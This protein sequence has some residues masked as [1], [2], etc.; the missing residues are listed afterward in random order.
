M[1]KTN[2]YQTPI[3]E[4][5]LESL[6]PEVKDQFLDSINNIPFIQ[7]LISP[8]R[9]RACDLDRDDKGR[10]IIDLAN[11][12]IVE[13]TDYFRPAAIHYQKH[14][15]Y[16]LL[17]P[18]SN[19]NSEYYKWVKEETRRCWEGYIRESD[20]EWVTGYLYF[21][22]NYSPIMLSAITKGT[23]QANR[24]YDFPE[25]WEGVYWR[26]HYM[27]QG[28]YG[29]KYNDFIGGNHGA[30][31]SSRGKA[32]PVT[33]KVPTPE[34]FKLWGDI[35]VGDLLFGTD[36]TTTKVTN[37]PYEGIEDIYN[38]YLKD[39]RMVQASGNHLFTLYKR[40]GARNSHRV[41]SVN[42]I[43]D[44]L[45]YSRKVTTRNPND[46][47]YKYALYNHS[48]VE[49]TYKNTL[50]D[51]YTFGLLLGDGCFRHKSCYYTCEDSDFLTIKKYLPYSHTKWKGKFGYNINIPKWNSILDFYNL[52]NLESED[53]FIPEEYIINSR[54]V[55]LEVLKGLMDSDGFVD[56]N[57]IPIIGLSSE[58]MIDNV[59]SIC[60]SLGYNC[61]KSVKPGGYK[62]DGV[63]KECKNSY[64]LRIYTTDI[65][66]KLPRKFKLQS[67]FISRYS[68]SN[69]KYSTIIDIQFSHKE[70]AKCVTVDSKDSNYLVGEYVP[71]HNSKS[72]SLSS[73][74][75][76]NFTLGINSTAHHKT[77][78]IVTAY[79]KEYLTKD[80]VLNKFVTNIDFLADNTQFPRKRLQSSF[81]QMA[82]KMGY[83]DAELDI[84]KGTLNTVLGVSS[85]DDESK[86]RGKRA[87]FIAI[88]EF[89]SFRK[90]KETYNVLIPSVQEG[91]IV[92]GQLFLTGTSGD[93]ESD[94]AGAQEIVYNPRG[95]N[96]YA[97][98]NNFDKVN[99]GKKEFV[100]FFGGYV[101]RKGCYN[102]DGVSDVVAAL[103][104]ILN[105][106][107][108]VK[109]NSSDPNTILKTIAEI[110]I[111][112]SEAIIKAGVNMFPVTDLT[113]RL[114]QLEANPNIINEIYT[115]ELVL[116]KG[117][118][119]YV[120]SQKEPIRD[121]PFKGSDLTGCLEIVQMPEKNREGSVFPDRYI[122]GLDPIDD[123]N[124]NNNNSLAAFYILDLWTDRLVAHYIGRPLYAEDLYELVRKALI[125]YNAR[126]NYE[127]NLKGIFS[128]FSQ[129]NCT[130]LLTDTLEF[131]KDKQ[132]IKSIG[133][134]NLSKGTRATAAINNYARNLLRSWL[135]KST[136]ETIVEEGEEKEVIFSN[137][138][139]IKSKEVLKELIG[140]NSEGNFDSISALGML[141]L[142]REDKMILYQ[143][144]V[145]NREDK[146]SSSYL[147][148]DP[149]F[150]D[151]YDN[152][153]KY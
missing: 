35:K 101:N 5:L 104:E 8:N 6:H 31:L 97:I 61:L 130:Y 60:R 30:E 33:Q 23:K 92:F 148:N 51:P 42:D 58:T 83:K 25:F 55:R 153:F 9:K 118:V 34:G 136:I 57:G 26:F 114:L 37:I 24:V 48:G 129:K 70:E 29:G 87:A 94:F 103:I 28:Y 4:E 41:L 146:S 91:D 84:D 115:A 18:N 44:D 75:S 1:I 78:S 81:Q 111:T 22:L 66:F 149:F 93:D 16:T 100:F 144:D 47:E 10:I 11:P 67:K 126:L 132:L 106:R 54:Q 63:F 39:G 152:R 14:G 98:P 90:L 150:K 151:N 131:L 120:P 53:K 127:N 86:L 56:S 13:D 134:G 77:T 19:P 121:F 137:L 116:Q 140:F 7:N 123:D 43:K 32:H 119:S 108:K 65:L 12:H 143:G 139:T 99:Q 69:L 107:F 49:Y 45:Y 102:S 88:E 38:I 89:G 3:T 113:E 59:A 141:M 145:N 110:P 62:V 50:I 117:E 73:I 142:L 68:Q 72:Y 17:K 82:W 109:Y 36:G 64:I 147:G 125:F 135:L 133:Y 27:Y 122:A 85:K 15:C 46:K 138:Y 52:N 105:N 80:G 74:L 71:T 40:S 96:M 112:P 21:Y 2:K 20:G 79:Q 76:H 95:Y 124:N 128:Y